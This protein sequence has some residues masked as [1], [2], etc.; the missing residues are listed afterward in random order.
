L[1]LDSLSFSIMPR[2][3]YRVLFVA[4]HPIQYASPIFRQMAQHPKLDIQVA[5]CSLQGAELGP[6]PEF[7]MEVKWD[8]PLLEGYPW[9]HVPNKSR[10]PT[11]GSFFGLVNPGLW[12]LVSSGHFDAVVVYTGYTCLSFWI[13]LAAAKFH[14][15]ALLFGTD[16]HGLAPRDGK[17]W[18]ITLKR[19]LWPRLF[20]LADVVIVPSSRSAAMMRSLGIPD[21]RLTLTP[22]VVDNDWWIQQAEQVDR[23]AVRAAWEV[24]EDASVVLFCAK[25]QPW[26]RPLDVL[27]AFAKSNVPGAHLVYA[28][29]GPLRREAESLARSL[30]VAERVHFIGFTNQSRLPAVYR[31]SDLLVL[32]SEYEPFGV[33]VN[34]AMLCG[35]ATAVSDRVGAGYD[36]VS[37]GQNGYVFPCGDVEA[38]AA[39]LRDALS[40]P[41]QLH[42]MGSGAR[43]RMDTWSPAQNIQALVQAV[44]RGITLAT[45]S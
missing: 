37:T 38:L 36:L 5:Y 17:S 11:L 19:V 4:S 13:A 25:L 23:R 26:K 2:D 42:R 31:A 28:G 16:A 41:Q 8:V 21:E 1:L 12:Q 10:H 45:A 35:C 29:E 43:R 44:D 9:V 22:Y 40:N 7:G 24:S 34:E 15:Q 30:G 3:R 33:V 18:K 27:R 6:D 14:R 32:P 20:S 39:I